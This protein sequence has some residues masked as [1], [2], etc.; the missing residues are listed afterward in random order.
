MNVTGK[1]KNKAYVSM[2]IPPDVM[3]RIDEVRGLIPRST[4]VSELLKQ[5]FAFKKELKKSK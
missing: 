3:E 5:H 1:G 4:Y 2:T